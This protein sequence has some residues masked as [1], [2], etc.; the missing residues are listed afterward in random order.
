M[1]KRT[2][3]ILIG[4][5]LFHCSFAQTKS[6]TTKLPIAA[7]KLVLQGLWAGPDESYYLLFRKDSVKEWE[8][9]GAD[10]TVKPFCAYT[11]SRDACDTASAHADSTTGIFLTILC[12]SIDYDE[13]RCYF[14]KSVDAGKLQLGTR[15][16][17]DESGE[18]KKWLR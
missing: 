3:N 17:F 8:S 5:F 1:Y 4:I 12:H 9:D 7:V 14:I 6:D 10:S 15:G 16:H 18:L 2:L 13:S 11:L